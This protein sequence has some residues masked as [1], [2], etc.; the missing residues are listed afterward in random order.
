MDRKKLRF[1]EESPLPDRFEL[2]EEVG[3]GGTSVVYR[4]YDRELEREVAV[5]LLPEGARGGRS[6]SAIGAR[7]ASWRG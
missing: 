1:D 3:R 5:K 2:V 7:R 4:A 6:A